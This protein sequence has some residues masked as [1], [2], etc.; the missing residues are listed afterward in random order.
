M[1][2]PRRRTSA[3]VD[4]DA[5]L[6]VSIGWTSAAIDTSRRGS[7]CGDVT[8]HWLTQFS[9]VTGNQTEMAWAGVRAPGRDWSLMLLVP[10]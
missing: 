9:D 8:T 2:T 3:A 5:C 10:S 4:R 6:G 1:S 7:S